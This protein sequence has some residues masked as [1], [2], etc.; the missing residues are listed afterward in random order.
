MEI[1]PVS[2]VTIKNK[3]PLFKGEEKANSIELIEL[4]EYGFYIVAQKDLYSVGDMAVYIQ[5]DYCLSDKPI[6]E[7]F[8]SPFGDPKK[9]RLGS[10]NRIRAAKFNLHIGDNKPVYSQ[11]VLLPYQEVQIEIDR[12]DLSNFNLTEEL[13]IVKWEEPENNNTKG[14]FLSAG[15]SQGF[16][17]GM[18]KTD[19]TNINNLWHHIKFPIEFIGTEKLMGVL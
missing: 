15:R 7:S 17:E 16:P 13:G 6:F 3:I 5:P 19:E 9:S 11:G 4:E 12:I 1:S 10:N 18:Y 14:G 2:I 8:I